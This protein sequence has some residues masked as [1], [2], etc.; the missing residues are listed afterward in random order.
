ML[1]SLIF[2]RCFLLLTFRYFAGEFHIR[3]A[4]RLMSDT[5]MLTVGLL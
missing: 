4:Y 5:D 1:F 2:M 3:L